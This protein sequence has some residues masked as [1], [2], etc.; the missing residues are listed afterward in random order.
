MT[1][2]YCP[3]C[4]QELTVR[5]IGDEGETPFCARCSRPWFDMFPAC[6]I[7]L[8]VNE[9]GEAALLRQAYISTDY[10]NLV[11]GYIKPGETAEE[12]AA[13]EILE[14]TGLSAESI[15]P[16]GT[17]WFEKK[18]MLMIGFFAHV[19]KRPFHLSAEVDGAEWAPVRDTLSMVHPEGSISYAL[20]DRYL[21]APRK[22]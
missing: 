12:A 6:V 7:A 2:H 13:R 11:S 8:I 4:G 1:F 5:S 10:R 22:E 19:Q 21:N 15:E 3:E 16:A 9:L 17:Y 14:E 18:Q 20:I